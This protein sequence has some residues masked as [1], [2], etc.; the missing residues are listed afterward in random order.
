MIYH[1]KGTTTGKEDG[2]ENAT[3]VDLCGSYEDGTKYLVEF[4]CAFNGTILRNYYDC[5]NGC[6]DGACIPEETAISEP[7]CVD[8]DGGNK[9]GTPSY[10]QIPVGVSSM[11]EVYDKCVIVGD[12]SP[13][14]GYYTEKWGI[15][16]ISQDYCGGGSCYVAEAVCS[17]TNRFEIIRCENG[18][19]NGACITSGNGSTGGDIGGG[20]RGGNGSSVNICS[21]GCSLNSNC[22]PIGYRTKT[23]YCNINGNFTIF[24]VENQECN[25]NFECSSNVCV[26]NQCISQNLIQRI[27]NWFK[28][29]FGAE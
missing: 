19:L 7:N 26:S 5:P 17:G 18:C 9:P 28:R 8:Y 4:S 21:S 14:N 10:V 25:N 29:L 15:K 13:A 20:A 2:Y 24:K 22:V 1:I 11:G 6:S 16:Y 12:S 27:L 3:E 23:N